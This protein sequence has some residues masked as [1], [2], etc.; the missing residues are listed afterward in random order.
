MLFNLGIYW[1]FFFGQRCSGYWLSDWSNMAWLGYNAA[2][3]N[4]NMISRTG[5]VNW[6][7]DGLMAGQSG[8]ATQNKLQTII[9]NVWPLLMS[10]WTKTPQYPPIQRVRIFWWFRCPLGHLLLDPTWGPTIQLL[11]PM[12][13]RPG[14]SGLSSKNLWPKCTV[15]S[16][17]NLRHTSIPQH[18][19]IHFCSGF[20]QWPGC[21]RKV[22][23]QNCNVSGENYD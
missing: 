12:H 4:E 10:S 5:D 21:V 14:N 17:W 20:T 18:T 8:T 9:Q 1:L 6:N 13:S 15:P 11:I 7:P 16:D 23:H 19:Y 2:T 22:M 3:V